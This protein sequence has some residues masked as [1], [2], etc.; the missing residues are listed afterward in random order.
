MTW[1][2]N[3]SAGELFELIRPAVILLSALAST[4]VLASA[5]QRRFS[6]SLATFWAL[7]TFFFPLIILP[8]YLVVRWS[9]KRQER[10][11]HSDGVPGSAISQ[12]GPRWRFTAPLAYAAVVFSL[13]GFYLYSDYQSVDARLSRAIQAKLRGDR[14]GTINEYRAALSLEDDPHTHNLFGIELAEQGNWS[15]ALSEFRSAERGGEPDDSIPFRIAT[16][17]ESLNQVGQANLEYQRFLESK[18]CTQPL[19]D[20]RCEVARRKV[21]GAD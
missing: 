14:S 18:T 8:L 11:A 20:D 9:R 2:L 10:A 15:D 3:M 5:R 4:W 16:L 17:L 6:L 13:I 19:P 1:R 7:G 21:Y 12:P